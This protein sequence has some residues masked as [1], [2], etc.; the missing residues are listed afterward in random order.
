MNQKKEF[1]YKLIA[2]KITNAFAADSSKLQKE[3]PNK[4]GIP[5]P[6]FTITN[7]DLLHV[8][9]DGVNRCSTATLLHILTS[10][11]AD[12]DTLLQFFA[13]ETFLEYAA[14]IWD[15]WVGRGPSPVQTT[16]LFPRASINRPLQHSPPPLL[17]QKLYTLSSVT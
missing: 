1:K 10:P 2:R 15:A 8:T 14:D 11:S 6:S 4:I 5:L 9:P 12:Q 3:C 13:H 17:T 7:P 16:L